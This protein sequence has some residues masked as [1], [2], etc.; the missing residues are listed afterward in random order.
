MAR[1]PRVHRTYR[2][3]IYPT[4]GQELALEA[5]LGFACDL[6]NA[7]LEQR[8]YARRV[9]RRIDYV[10]QCRDLTALRAAGDGPPGMS[11]SAMR[12]PLR[13]VE[14][15]YRGFFRRVNVGEKPGYPRFPSRRLYDRLTWDSGWSI[16]ERRLAV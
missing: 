3:R 13:R 6:Y 8:R 7:A 9:G 16:R 4:R 10:T 11:C 15:A 12:N 14:R 1:A 5:Q 2:F